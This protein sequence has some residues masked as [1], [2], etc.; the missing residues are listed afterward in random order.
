M[1]HMSWQ[2]LLAR[3]RRL[4]ST[5]VAVVIG[6][7][8]L[9]GTIVLGNTIAANFDDLFSDTAAGTDV[10]V[11]SE[12]PL[13]ASLEADPV[14]RPIDASLV[15]EIAAIDGVDVAEGQVVGYGQL[16]GADGDPIGGNGPPRLAGSW[17]T[18]PDLNPYELA[19]GRA[20]EAPDEVVVNRGAAD[21]GDLSVG[22]R[23]VIQTPAPLEVTIVGISTFGSADGLGETTM[24][25]F[26]LDAAQDHVTPQPGTV[27]SIVVKAANGQD[28]DE[29]SARIGEMLPS[30]V[31]AITGDELVDQRLDS[32]DFL[33][34]LRVFLVAF[35]AI[36]LFVATLSINN[37][38]SITVAQRTRELA[39]LRSIGASGTQVRRMV[40]FEALIVGVVAS[41]VG[42]MAGLGVAALLKAMFAGFGLALP[43]GGLT[44]GAVPLIVGVV[45][46][47]VATVLAARAPARRA[48]RVAPIEALRASNGDGPAI[49]RRRLLGSVGA[50]VV[51]CG[52]SAAGV[53]EAAALVGLG[54]VALVVGT[55]MVAPV[56][57]PTFA[58]LL[59]AVLRR[60]RGASGELAEQNA[61]RQPRRTA[62]TATA[63]LIG[64]SV[65]T[66][67]TV[68]AASSAGMIN[69]NVSDGFGN[70]DLSIA[71]PVF[72]G[73]VLSPDVLSELDDVAEIDQAVGVS[74]ATVV[75]DGDE[76]QAAAADMADAAGVLDVNVIDGSLDDLGPD[77]L[78]VGETR[79]DDEDWSVGSAVDVTY[80]DGSTL[81][82]KVGAVMDDNDVLAGIVVPL[83]T[84]F[85]RVPQPAYTNVFVTLVDSVDLDDGRAALTPIAA[86]YTG[87]VQDR[88]EFA[89]AAAAGLD[90]LLGVVYAMLALAILISLL[91]IANTLALAVNER[92]REI[93]LLRAVG[94]TRRQ[95][96]SVLRLESV[97]VAAFG[98]LLGLVLGGVLGGLL[99]A[100]ISDGAG[101]VVPWLRLTIILVVGM[102]AGLLAAWRPAR[103]AARLDVLDAIATV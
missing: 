22:D 74:L 49:S 8:F 95:T 20:P 21:A 60:V 96:R 88:A 61:R 53:G 48:A 7:A 34:T 9:V 47:V 92:R 86:R 67:F 26:T 68:F 76:I 54:A 35:A 36:A 12:S 102:V 30:G 64:V 38:F 50:L 32:L 97:I 2:S 4:A 78:V 14:R 43:T 65:V 58:R 85:E 25:A 94:Q 44:I 3:R 73:G 63:L 83:A 77:E 70:A 66:M 81:P 75:V 72:G 93:G 31:E 33:G 89:D 13:N 98:T 57:L 82:M 103:R 24:T 40:T 51:G 37:T 100:A 41:L 79:A 39:L 17:I 59:G 6:V 52:L 15:D 80:P 28:A 18:T 19:E 5:A 84:W 1:L 11:R 42:A 87:D 99:F 101:V 45:V 62:S 69:R 91:G 90:L 27:S 56:L 46:G 71:T 10:V 23:T 55:L 29:L 16:L